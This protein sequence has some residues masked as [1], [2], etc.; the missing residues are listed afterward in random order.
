MKGNTWSLSDTTEG[1]QVLYLLEK[2]DA[3]IKIITKA[4]H[5]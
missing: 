3:Y 5:Y 4:T 2:R 1:S